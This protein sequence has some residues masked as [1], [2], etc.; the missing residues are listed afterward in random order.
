MFIWLDQLVIFSI[1]ALG[2]AL[3][4]RRIDIFEKAVKMAVSWWQQLLCGSS[5]SGILTWI[6]H[7]R[8]H[9]AMWM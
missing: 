3:E 8:V 4:T 6:E 7:A 5:F 2:I 9:T 1:Q